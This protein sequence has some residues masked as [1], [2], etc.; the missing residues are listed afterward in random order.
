M[1]QLLRFLFSFYGLTHVFGY[2]KEIIS[3]TFEIKK[4]EDEKCPSCSTYQSLFR[5]S[6][7]KMGIYLMLDMKKAFQRN[8][9]RGKHSD[10]AFI[11]FSKAALNS[12]GLEMA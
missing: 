5:V 8:A 12:D 10:Y 11:C 3:L 2:L 9:K 7:C 1:C 6:N 4:S